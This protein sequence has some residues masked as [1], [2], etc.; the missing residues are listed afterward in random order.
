MPTTDITDHKIK[1]FDEIESNNEEESKQKME[2]YDIE[3]EYSNDFGD[4]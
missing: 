3:D 2:E 4:I 1:T